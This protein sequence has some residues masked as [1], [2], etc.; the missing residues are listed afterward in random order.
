MKAAQMA[1][2]ASFLANSKA[3][4]TPKEL[5]LREELEAQ[6]KKEF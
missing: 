6:F 5:S 2:D 4:E 1:K 3:V